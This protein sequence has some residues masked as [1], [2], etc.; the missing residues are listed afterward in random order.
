MLLGQSESQSSRD[1]KYDGKGGE[2]PEGGKDSDC[3]VGT[4]GAAA[5]GAARGCDREGPRL[6][7]DS[8]PSK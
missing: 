5:A 8:E 2:R 1:N 3:A 6:G 7:A 4:G